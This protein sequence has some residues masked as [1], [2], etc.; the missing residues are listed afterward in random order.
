MWP[1]KST[2]QNLLWQ[3]TETHGA[4]DV[5]IGMLRVCMTE[6]QYCID[7]F[8]KQKTVESKQCC[9]NKCAHLNL[10]CNALLEKV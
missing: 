8:K 10:G 2:C 6:K 3:R 5:F 1:L 9:M 7:L 4:P